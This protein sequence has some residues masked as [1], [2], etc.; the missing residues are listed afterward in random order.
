MKCFVKDMFIK[1]QHFPNV[2]VLLYTKTKER[3]DILVIYS[4]VWDHFNGPAQLTSTE[5]VC[6]PQCEMSL[7]PLI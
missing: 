1:F 7:T 2:L 3:H 6:G 4:R 5:A